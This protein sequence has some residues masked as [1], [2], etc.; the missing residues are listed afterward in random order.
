[1]PALHPRRHSPLFTKYTR[2]STA[3][4]LNLSPRTPISLYR[5]RNRRTTAMRL[6]LLFGALLWGGGLLGQHCSATSGYSSMSVQLVI[7]E[8]CNVRL[9]S[10]GQPQVS[11]LHH[12][13]YLISR[14]PLSGQ[15]ETSEIP[16]AD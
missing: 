16:L 4:S 7:Q 15:P 3:I 10:A 1:M 11:C 12:H 8:S 6:F 9:D 14:S 5:H 2:V 13:P